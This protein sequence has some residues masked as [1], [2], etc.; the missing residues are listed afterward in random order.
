MAAENPILTA[1]KLIQ[2]APRC[3][4]PKIWCDAINNAMTEFEINN[5]ARIAAFLAQIL[6]ESGEF[7]HLTENL[8]YTSAAS[9]YNLWPKKMK[10]TETAEKYVHNSMALANFAYADKNGNGKVDSGDGWRYRGR[11]LIQLTGRANYAQ[12]ASALGLPLISS[13]ALLEQPVNAARSAAWFWYFNGLNQ[14]AD[15][16]KDD[17]DNADFVTIT[18]RINS[19]LHALKERRKYWSKA[20]KILAKEDPAKVVKSATDQKADIK[21]DAT[22]ATSKN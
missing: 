10:N 19:K 2:I 1:E 22:T 15:D 9:I 8:N 11:G 13:P 7:T 6:H 4:D 21:N 18:K 3:P 17:D 20:K 5:L 14:L 12:A 16:L